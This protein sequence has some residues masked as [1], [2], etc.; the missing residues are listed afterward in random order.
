MPAVSAIRFKKR[1]V[2]M[3]RMQVAEARYKN[4]LA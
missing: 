2:L 4:H 1:K 3:W